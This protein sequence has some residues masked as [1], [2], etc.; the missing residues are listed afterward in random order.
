MLERLHLKNVGPASELEMNFAPRLNII[1]GDNGLGK[2]FLLDVAW[3]ALTET[4]RNESHVAY[5][6]VKKGHSVIEYQKTVIPFDDIFRRFDDDFNSSQ[7]RSESREFNY[8]PRTQTWG[9]GAEFT[10]KRFNHSRFSSIVISSSAEGSYAIADPF[11]EII[12]LSN[13]Q[14][15]Q[16]LISSGDV[17]IKGLINDWIIWQL[18]QGTALEKLQQALSVFSPSTSEP[19]EL[20]KPTRVNLNDVLD[21]PTL[22]MPYGQE[23]PITL[24]SSAI[25]RIS[26]LAYLLV[27]AWREHVRTADLQQFLPIPRIVF[28]ID[29]LETHLHPQWQR[30]ILNSL[31]KVAQE[32]LKENANVQIIATTHSPLVMAS[33]EPLFDEKQ[34]AW[35][36]LNLVNNEV[37]LERMPWRKRGGA[38][39]WLVSEAFDLPSDENTQANAVLEKAA[40]AYDDPKL[41]KKKFLELDAELRATLA[42]SHPFW[43]RWQFWGEKKGWL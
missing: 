11:R 17:K 7:L 18:E 28:L 3:W 31:L 1:T 21:I 30:V 40:K 12:E 25:K 39:A 16:G 2:S 10:T 15:W 24:A 27:W 26:A 33:L 6:H 43:V 38:A 41:S 14:V 42:E 9:E 13:E 19:L 23:V 37:K 34:D 8:F 5:P 35:F 32:V 29:E 20:G 36:D 4:W 22:K